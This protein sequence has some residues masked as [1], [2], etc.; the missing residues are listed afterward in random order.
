[1]DSSPFLEAGGEGINL[2]GCLKGTRVGIV[3]LFCGEI[4]II[5]GRGRAGISPRTYKLRSLKIKRQ[6]GG[7]GEISPESAERIVR[8]LVKHGYAARPLF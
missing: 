5:V 2:T 6:K 4:Y 7:G 3:Y 1:M 8:F